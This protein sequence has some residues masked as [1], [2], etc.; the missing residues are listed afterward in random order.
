ML[1]ISRTSTHWAALPE[2]TARQQGRGHSRRRRRRRRCPRHRHRQGLMPMKWLAE[3]TCRSETPNGTTAGERRCRRHSAPL[4]AAPPARRPAGSRAPPLRRSTTA[5]RKDPAEPVLTLAACSSR[6][7]RRRRRR[8]HRRRTRQHQ[9]RQQQHQ[10]YWC[11]HQRRPQRQRVRWP[12]DGLAID[13]SAT[14]CER[15]ASLSGGFAAQASASSSH[16]APRTRTAWECRRWQSCLMAR[17]LAD[18]CGLTAC[19]RRKHQATVRPCRSILRHLDRA[20]IGP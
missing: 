10:R 18:D 19:W 20:L 12:G 3:P 6:A 11:Q 9:R 13:E 8:R 1:T 4:P 14:G 5:I 7:R 17:G 15:L 16:D 2:V